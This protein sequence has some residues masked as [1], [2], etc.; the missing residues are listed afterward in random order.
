MTTTR[1]ALERFV[2]APVV[3]VVL[4]QVL[5][6]GLA[7]VLL[8]ASGPILLTDEG[9][10]LGVAADLS[11]RDASVD[12]SGNPYY[13][14]GISLLIAPV[15]SVTSL[16]P[17]LAGLAV[18]VAALAV[19]GPILYALARRALGASPKVAAFAAVAG[20]TL[21]SLGVNVT[22]VWPEVLLA[23]LTAAWALLLHAF[24]RRASLA[25]AVGLAGLALAMWVT[26]HRTVTMLAISAAVLVAVPVHTAWTRRS[27]RVAEI[28]RIIAAGAGGLLVLLVGYRAIGAFEDELRVRLFEG[29]FT[30][31][32]AGNMLPRV[33]SAGS[34]KKV[35]GHLWSTQIV[36]LGFAAIAA[37]SVLSD[38]ISGR[39][40]LWT[41]IVVVAFAG[42]LI[43]STSFLSTGGRVDTF[44]YER[45]MGIHFPLLVTVGVVGFAHGGAQRERLGR[46][47]LV[48]TGVAF[49]AMVLAVTTSVFRSGSVV[50]STIPTLTAWDL[51]AGDRH[52]SGTRVL[53]IGVITV[54]AV[55]VG[56]GLLVVHRRHRAVAGAAVPLVF[57]AL[58]VAVAHFTFRPSFDFF[59]RS[60][61]EA[62]DLFEEEGVTQYGVAV[63]TQAEVRNS[64][65]YRTGY[66]PIVKGVEADTCPPVRF[67]ISSGAF[68]PEFAAVRVRDLRP[69]GGAVWETTCEAGGP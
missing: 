28:G 4:V 23:T 67:F 12:L 61:S 64:V 66:L 15:L 42:T 19:L 31:I 13:S 9:S 29:G 22:R 30:Y 18:N 5:F 3:L 8:D 37:L 20:G 63:K 41:A 27:D 40:R 34:L 46:T 69:F 26:H 14:P 36:T 57:M 39:A 59:E 16:D 53:D 10:Y 44:V 24:L 35:P 45:Y 55:L 48:L 54:A 11:T 49:L 52:P 33:L 47:S 25:R 38:R 32:E 21:P 58:L 6:I 43:V 56:Y 2:R 60:G 50:P 1:T 7:L 17:W 62:A 65:A 51:L 68:E